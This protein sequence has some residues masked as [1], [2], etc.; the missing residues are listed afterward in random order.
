[1]EDDA[2][3]AARKF[4]SVAVEMETHGRDRVANQQQCAMRHVRED[5]LRHEDAQP[6][7]RTADFTLKLAKPTGH[8]VR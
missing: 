8:G 7:E 5:E 3:V 6:F 4:A 1:M 2:Q